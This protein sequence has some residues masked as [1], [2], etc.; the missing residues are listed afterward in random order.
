MGEESESQNMKDENTFTSEESGVKYY[1]REEIQA[2]NM[3]KDTWLII[4]D[5]VYDITS[6]MEEVR[7]LEFHHVLQSTLCNVNHTA[8]MQLHFT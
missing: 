7:G 1:T 8:L 6:F 4:H 3:I 2:H 5:K